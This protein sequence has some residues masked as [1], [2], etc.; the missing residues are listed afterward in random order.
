[1][2][3]EE[4][5]LHIPYSPPPYSQGLHMHTFGF[6]CHTHVA[7]MIKWAWLDILHLIDVF[8]V[9]TRAPSPPH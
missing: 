4:I 8:Y 5:W 9:A 2:P 6:S 1:M 3:E 7:D